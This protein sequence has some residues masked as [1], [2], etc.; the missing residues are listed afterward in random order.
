MV[1]TL[2]RTGWLSLATLDMDR[3]P[4][5]LFSYVSFPRSSSYVLALPAFERCFLHRIDDFSEPLAIAFRGD[6][7][8]PPKTNRRSLDF[9]ESFLQRTALSLEL[10]YGVRFSTYSISLAGGNAPE[11]TTSSRLATLLLCCL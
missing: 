11:Y 4:G 6:G 5:L 1:T 7:R 8:Y 9:S 3:H 10:A 2:P